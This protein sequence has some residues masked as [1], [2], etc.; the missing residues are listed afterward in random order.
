M[1]RKLQYNHRRTVLEK[2]QDYLSPYQKR[3]ILETGKLTLP[4]FED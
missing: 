2:G 3:L 1:Y 4:I